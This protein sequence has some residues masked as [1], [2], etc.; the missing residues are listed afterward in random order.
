[1]SDIDILVDNGTVVTMDPRRQVIENAS[2][3]VQ[4]KR[5][6]DVGPADQLRRKY[7]PAK[8][9]DARRKVIMP[10]LVDLHAHAGTSL[11]KQVAE[12]FPG[13]EWRRS[14]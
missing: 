13:L 2:V 5:I 1:M 8:T 7:Q 11:I 3:A 4:A 12:R 9:I 6:L 14:S 10:G